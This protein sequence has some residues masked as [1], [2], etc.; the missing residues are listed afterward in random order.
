MEIDTRRGTNWPVIIA[1]IISFIIFLVG[2]LISIINTSDVVITFESIGQLITGNKYLWLL[3]L[4][5]IIFPV[6]VYFYNKYIIGLLQKLSTQLSEQVK[7]EQF[8]SQYVDN[9]IHEKYDIA[10][11]DVDEKDTLSLSLNNL[12]D[13]LKRNKDLVDKQR[14]EDENRNWHAEGQAKF[15]EIL[16]SNN[17]FD[18]LAFNV[19]KDLTNYVGAIQGGF[20]HLEDKGTEKYFDLVAFY[21]YGRKKYA[22]EKIPFGRGLI[23]TAIKEGKTIHMKKVPEG[24]IR[25]T[26]GLGH[27]IPKQLVVVPLT[28]DGQSFG[29]IEIA[30]LSEFT[31]DHIEFINKVCESTASTLSTVRMN[32]QTAKLLEESNEQAQA[33]ASQEEEMRQNMEELKAT[34]EE[35]ARQAEQFMKLESTVNHTMIRAEYSMNGTLLYANTNFL[36]KLEYTSNAQV[37]GKS[38]SMFIASKDKEWFDSI[39]DKLSKGGRHF[40]GY[41][42]HV[43]RTGKDLWTMAT[44]TCIRN[45]EGEAEKILF[46]ALDTTEQKKLMLN[47]EGFMEAVDRSSIKIEFDINGNIKSFSDSFLFL[48]KY[49]EKETQKLNVF[50]LIDS[51]ELETF[52]KK[53]ESIVNGINFEGQFK[54]QTKTKEESWIQGAFSAVYNMYDEVD[55]V[56]FIGNDN[57][58]QKKMEM[59]FINQNDIL[60]KQE[61]LLKESEKELNRKLRQAK[62]EMQ[63][64]FKEIENTKIRNERTLEGALDSILQTTKDNKIIF[65]NKAAENLLG[66]KKDEVMGQTIDMLFTKEIIE[67]NDFVGRYVK[68]DGEKLVGVRTEIKMK[69]KNG[70]EL[71]VL[72]LLSKAQ[73]DKETTYTAFIQT[74][75]VELF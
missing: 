39:W 67:N 38:I 13:T 7:K 70:N 11:D 28:S 8:I 46:L 36:K 22:D 41:M 48:F 19:I 12:L 49:K 30:T 54:V 32:M 29:V 58:R 60:K 37:E 35:A 43:T 63:E 33:L 5:L 72:I 61:I 62:Q 71:P 68:A 69:H 56:I 6:A 20:Y 73:V 26:S 1:F 25:V 14:K 4:Q 44:Y 21:A 50:D 2:I 57:T 24:Y 31:T 53:W 52:N 75:E 40:E 47:L 42:K 16:R 23:S 9:L 3:L 66:Y 74:I 51:L 64:Q 15:G 55:K 45:E 17:D 18:A 59:E 27:S 10:F 65:Y 34:Q